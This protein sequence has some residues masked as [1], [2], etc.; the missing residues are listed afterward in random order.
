VTR[1]EQHMFAAVL[2]I[3]AVLMVIGAIA[4]VTR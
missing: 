3:A 4:Q 2:I 1:V